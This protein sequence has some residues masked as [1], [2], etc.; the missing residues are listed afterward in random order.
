MTAPQHKS[1]FSQ[2]KSPASI[3]VMLVDDSVVAR[4]IFERILSQRPEIEIV[5]Q[6]GDT[7]SALKGLGQHK[8]DIILLDIEMPRR[9]GL[10]AL[11]DFIKNADGARILVVSSFAEENG[12]AAIQALSLGACDTLVK[13]GRS[14][15]T[16]QFSAN[17]I[18][19]VV[20]LGQSK[21]S[22]TPATSKTV[23]ATGKKLTGTPSCVAIGASTGGIP[24][25]YE[26]IHNLDASLECP[27][28]ITQHLPFSFMTF[29]ARQLEAQTKRRVVV[30]EEGM[31][32]IDNHIYIAPGKAHIGFELVGGKIQIK[33]LNSY[34]RSRYCPS[35]DAMFEAVAEFYNANALAI[36]LS[37]MGN[38]GAYG[39]RILNKS[40]ATIL[41]QD[42]HSSVVW[43]MPGAVA[44]EGLAA[45]IMAP[46]KIAE[47]INSLEAGK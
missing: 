6:A 21:K 20:R 13:P 47:L 23:R 30:A 2:R 28:F 29:F 7:E 39:A 17:L 12:P 41:V 22:N 46:E 31:E 16:G 14:G 34:P 10:D 26:I 43:G 27:I 32:V 19:K 44:K 9:T 24:A 33:L 45:A 25:I 35:V 3:R 11:P 18:E 36:I 37:G 4:S 1:G 8:V 42:A 38:D 40:N 15:F 5:Y